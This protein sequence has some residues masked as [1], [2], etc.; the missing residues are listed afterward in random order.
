MVRHLYVTACMAMVMSAWGMSAARGQHAGD[1]WIG[2]SAGGQLKIDTA[3]DAA[4]GFDPAGAVTVLAPDA[5]GGFSTDSPG[6]DRITANQPAG[7]DMYTLASGAQI[8]LQIVGSTANPAL[9]DLLISPAL[10]IYDPPT[11]FFY[12]YEQGSTLYREVF[13]GTHQVHKHVLWFV[14]ALDPAFDPSQCVWEVTLRLIDKGTTGYSPSEPFTL[15]FSLRPLVP[16]DFD[17]DGDVDEDDLALFEA[18]HAGPAI[19]LQAG[20][21]K[22]DLDGDGDADAT[23]FAIFQRCWSGAGVP[24]NPACAG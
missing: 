21:R 2:R 11:F 18:C 23:D 4:C 5:F 1:I 22:F 13:L 9:A 12:P 10:S 3:C 20:C 16:G 24:G 7:E 6:F 8:W 19:L 15:R 14:D 17:C